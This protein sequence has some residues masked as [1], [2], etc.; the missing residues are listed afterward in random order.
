MLENR[1]L[2]HKIIRRGS[3]LIVG[4]RFRRKEESERKRERVCRCEW[5]KIESLT[6]ALK[7]LIERK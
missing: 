3:E 7:P 6:K 5:V 4:A 1:A 2:D